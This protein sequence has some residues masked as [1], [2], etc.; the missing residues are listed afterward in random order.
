MVRSLADNAHSVATF[1][2]GTRKAHLVFSG[3][4]GQKS[5]APTPGANQ[6]AR[7][8]SGKPAFSISPSTKRMLITA[9]II[10]GAIVLIFAT[11][12]FWVQW[13]WFD[14]LGY[15]SVLMR[16]YVGQSVVFAIAGIIAAVVFLVNVSIALRRSREATDKT[17]RLTSIADRLVV[18][19]AV[20]SALVLSII[21][22]LAASSRWDAWLLWWYSEPFG[23][24]DPV[25]NRDIG[26][27][28]FAVPAM[29]Q[30]VDILM[31]LT[32]ASL[33][34]VIVVYTLR[35]GV[36]LRKFRSVPSLMRVHVLALSG[37]IFVLLAATHL[38][39]NFDLAYSTRGSAFGAGYTDVH[40]LRPANWIL[41]IMALVIGGLLVA[42][43][44][45]QRIKYLVGAMALWGVL[46]VVL[47]IL[48][49]T[50]VQQTVVEPSELKREMEYIENNIAMTRNAYALDQVDMR[51]LSGQE[52]ITTEKLN[53]Y[54]QT[55]TNIRLW[56]YR[57]IRGTFQQLQSFVPYYVFY[58]VDV[59]RYLVGDKYQQVL[60]SARELDQGGLPA[61]AQT[62]TNERLVYTH[63]Y[64]A[65]VSP[66]GEVSRQ[67]L[68]TFLVER[69]PPSGEGIYAITQPEIYFGEAKLDWVAV[70][71]G[72]AEFS[73][74]IDN[75]DPT[76]EPGYSG[77]GKGSIT[78]SNYFKKL[79]VAAN[80]GDRNLLLSG[81]ITSD[82][83]VML[84]RNIID[85]VELIAPFL[86]YD[87]DP[88]MVIADGKL[89]WIIDAYT[90]TNLYPHATRI[91]GINYLRNSVKVVIDA[92][93]GTVTYYRTSEA[94][95]IADA[96]SRLYGDL[97]RPIT[98]A[99]SSIAVHFR[100]PEQLFEIQSEIFSTFHVNDATAF[101]NGEDQW[102][103]P[104]EQVGG[105][106]QRMEG[107]YVTMTLPG[108][109]DPE[110]ALI[111]PFIPGGRSQRQNMTSWMAG[112][113]GPDGTTSLV[114]YR[115][116]R[117]ET[118]FGPSQI[119]ARINQEPAISAQIT[120]WSQSGSEVLRGNLLVIPVGES[121]LYVQPLYLQATSNEGSLPELKRVIVASNEQVVMGETLQDALGQLTG[122]PVAEIPAP[123]TTDDETAALPDLENPDIRSLVD[124]AVEAYDRG[125]AALM[126]GDWNSYG[127]AQTELEAILEE[128]Q[129]LSDGSSSGATSAS[130]TPVATPAAD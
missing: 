2:P 122:A 80:L 9:A 112:R 106:S 90:S 5:K 96:Y 72:Q 50:A 33:A 4:G 68:P 62:W 87:A 40:V 44:F 119:E 108:E 102:E 54:P 94:D 42:N 115:F 30:T 82:T 107:Y 43:G 84:H 101:Y 86:D 81:N 126:V 121:I 16:R 26:F 39:A 76:E 93:D 38:L 60:I 25:F 78:L 21:V 128:L 27:F 59:D 32:L 57:I 18:I 3:I 35:L 45:V 99:P 47:G 63:G 120:L 10:L 111:R 129:A 85:R 53:E 103:V 95:P 118:V 11:A 1:P 98:E 55:L 61:T 23:V 20:G 52:P 124:Q 67:G 31:L 46:Y 127:E 58:D 97:F 104:Q 34:A 66:V 49:P 6:K 89:Y 22:G 73:G 91:N 88:Y 113:L 83:R 125:Q 12:A 51:E 24:N 130:A 7:P 114:V 56:D 69:I 17:G 110:F 100:Y 19:L 117:Q 74:L 36:D 79:L 65:V 13:W 15:S 123:D 29:H 116:P 105:V 75:T 70:N 109:P 77:L 48:V 71:T 8:V 37:F 14:S 28:V 41:A 92:Y 64:G